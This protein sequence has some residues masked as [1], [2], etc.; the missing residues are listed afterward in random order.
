MHIVQLYAVLEL[1]FDTTTPRGFPYANNFAM[2][3]E[4]LPQR[5]PTMNQ[6]GKNS[7]NWVANYSSVHCVYSQAH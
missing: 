2:D 1:C 4:K 5:N 6:T 7:V 3:K